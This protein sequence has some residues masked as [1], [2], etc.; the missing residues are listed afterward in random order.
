MR[1][2][3]SAE[4]FGNNLGSRTTEH[5]REPTIGKRVSAGGPQ[6]SYGFK[7]PWGRLLCLPFATASAQTR[8]GITEQEAYEI[9]VEAYVYLHPLI[10][11][12]VTRRVHRE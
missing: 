3:V 6:I 7:S 9:A 11:M 2:A 5:L 10:T 8:G 1:G 12:D 4:S